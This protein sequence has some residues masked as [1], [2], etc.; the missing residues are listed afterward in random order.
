MTSITVQYC[1][2]DLCFLLQIHRHVSDLVLMVSLHLD[3]TALQT[4]IRVQHVPGRRTG[5]SWF[6]TALFPLL[7][8]SRDT[9]WDTQH[10][11]FLIHLISGLQFI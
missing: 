1:K 11:P 5:H 2:F 6:T 10:I 3:Q 8:A 9:D 7:R 4:V